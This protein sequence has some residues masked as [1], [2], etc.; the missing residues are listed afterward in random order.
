M[1]NFDFKEYLYKFEQDF[2]VYGFENGFFN[3]KKEDVPLKCKLLTTKFGGFIEHE[4][5]YEKFLAINYYGLFKFSSEI[6]RKIN[7]YKHIFINIRVIKSPLIHFN[8][9]KKDTITKIAPHLAE[10]FQ[11]FK[12]HVVFLRWK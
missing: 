1:D 5:T 9:I 6:F 7:N 11:K 8:S 10:D 12:D 3:K 2:L 4:F